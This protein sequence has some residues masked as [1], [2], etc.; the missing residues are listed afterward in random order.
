M[1][2]AKHIGKI[3][4]TQESEASSGSKEIGLHADASYLI[5]GGLGG[6][7]LV[8]SKWMVEKGARHLVLMGRS[9]PSS[10]AQQA[11]QEMKEQ[12]AQVLVMQADVSNARQV[13]EVFKTMERQMPPLR[14]VIHAAGALAD[15][16]LINQDWSG[17]SK[18]YASKVDG[19]WHL[20][21]HTRNMSLD[22]FV[23]F[24]S[25]ASLFGSRGQANHAAANTFMDMLAYHRQAQGLPA[26][27]INW[28]AWSQTG[29]A[30]EYG[31]T[32]RVAQQGMN[33][34]SPEEGLR[35]LETLLNQPAPQVG[36]AP[37]TWPV[38]MK[39]YRAGAEPPF[40]A[41][42]VRGLQAR[43]ETK[44]PSQEKRTD[45]LI[46][47]QQAPANKRQSL[48][49]AYVQ[50]QVGKVLGVEAGQK[51]NEYIPLSEMGLDS[52]MAVEVRNILGSELNLK[53]ALPATLV[54][55]YPTVAAIADYIMT[56]MDL[57]PT[58]AKQESPSVKS[59]KNVSGE[60]SM[61]NLLDA[62]EGL[63]DE[64]V[65]RMLAEQMK[66]GKRTDE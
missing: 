7:G 59:N 28:G 2:K 54:F 43:M 5:T 19:T 38:F 12:G 32:E 17:F 60:G 53:R 50:S 44:E 29:A 65:D 49:I 37:I 42:M 15:G 40:F 34:F 58:D 4:V 30:V 20:H 10:A 18:V 46:Q 26:M 22:F 57:V 41:N 21:E 36:V 8:V 51:V 61:D 66:E 14:G 6:L 48:L 39:Q 1:T 63:S 56:E 64:D 16:I 13:T 33:T 52:L 23:M 11:I 9:A 25:V 47:L 45:L 62:L 24:S 31:V 3:V 35:V 55:D 27:S